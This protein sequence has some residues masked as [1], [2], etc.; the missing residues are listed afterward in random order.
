M[1]H[2]EGNV[3]KLGGL[4]ASA[5]RVSRRALRAAVLSSLILAPVFGVAN[6]FGNWLYQV[7]TNYGVV[8]TQGDGTRVAIDKPGW[9][10][11]A[12]FVSTYEEE[13]PLANQAIF[14]HGKTEP[15]QVVT[16]E[17]STNEG[18]VV[19]AS[20][21]TFYEIVDLKRYAIDNI[22]VE[23]KS[24]DS[25]T[26]TMSPKLMLQ[27]TLD[28]II[29]DQTQRTNPKDLIHDRSKVEKLIFESL[30]GSG[31]SERYGIKI[32]SFN[33]T[34]T[35]YIASV[36]EANAQ[37]QAAVAKAEGEYVAAQIKKKSIETLAKAEYEKYRTMEKALDPKT[38]EEK[39][40]VQEILLKYI[41]LKERVGDT[42]WV[43]P[44]STKTLP[45]SNSG[46]SIK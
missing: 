9:Y 34:E 21:A 25:M 26:I 12:P 7:K 44:E 11:R 8:I 42:V 39:R 41:T 2:K 3:A 35:S 1:V 10:L 22:K 16:K 28:S 36:V 18:S 33:F 15:H 27:Q 20:A 40:F 29:G 4:A 31:I 24:R 6:Y 46:I 13:C 43:I 17:G 37:K 32:N 23:L 45:V 30:I 14:L 19:M 5:G 38:P